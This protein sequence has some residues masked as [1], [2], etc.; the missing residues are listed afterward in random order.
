MS[1]SL[2][3]IIKQALFTRTPSDVIIHERNLITELLLSSKKRKD[4]ITWDDFIPKK[5]FINRKKSLLITR[6]LIWI[7]R[8]V[9]FALL[10]ILY[11]L[12]NLF[13]YIRK[14]GICFSIKK[15]VCWVIK[16]FYWVY[17]IISRKY[18]PTHTHIKKPH[19]RIV[20]STSINIVIVS[21]V[22]VFGIVGTISILSFLI[23]EVVVPPNEAR[24]N[25]Q[26]TITIDQPVLE[27]TS[28]FLLNSATPWQ[29]TGIQVSEGDRVYIT[30]SG[31]VYS[32]VGELYEK[33]KNNIPPLYY[34]S[35]FYPVDDKNCPDYS[36]R[37]KQGAE[38][39]IYGRNQKTDKLPKFGS[40]LYQ[41]CTEN[42]GPLYYN[43]NDTANIIQ[44]E[45]SPSFKNRKC[46]FGDDRYHIDVKKSGII[47]LSINDILLD[48]EI[49]NR[50]YI[51]SKQ[52]ELNAQR[53]WKDDFIKNLNFDTI[54]NKIL[55]NSSQIILNAINLE[56]YPGFKK[57][58]DTSSTF[59]LDSTQYN[60]LKEELK[61]LTSDT[62]LLDSLGNTLEELY[63]AKS[64]IDTTKVE[65]LTECLEKIKKYIYIE[66]AKYIDPT[67]WFQDNSGDV[68]V[69]IHI[70]KNISNSDLLLH[71]KFLAWIYRSAKKICIPDNGHNFWWLLA[72]VLIYFIIDIS[73]S[74]IIKRG[75]KNNNDTQQNTI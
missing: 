7:L 64:S 66:P 28:F 71:K 35:C 48:K 6:W 10:C 24:M 12:K 52:K 49:I 37:M 75:K 36:D 54:I 34:R 31:S 44:L 41:T 65:T 59:S 26:G 19:L 42:N 9:V 60:K 32:D 63:K 55:I 2:I 25:A 72:L 11:G 4:P 46:I 51:Q 1:Q 73:I 74:I 15:G 61:K 69:T 45:F 67:I 3:S 58:R 39:C 5:H 23:K 43:T 33:V 57:L 22:I 30:A 18:H 17:Y 68:L 38:F 21:I 40:L 29:S 27:T 53:I 20:P 62:S 56:K 13:H 16:L 50:L 14:K 47:Y 70:E 8:C